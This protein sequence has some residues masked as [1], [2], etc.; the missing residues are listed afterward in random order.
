MNLILACQ[1]WRGLRD[2]GAKCFRHEASSWLSKGGHCTHSGIRFW[3]D[4]APPQLLPGLWRT[5]NSSGALDKSEEC[6]VLPSQLVA[7]QFLPCALC[8][9]LTQAG[10]SYLIQAPCASASSKGKS[11]ESPKE[12]WPNTPITMIILFFCFLFNSLLQQLVRLRSLK[13]CQAFGGLETQ[14]V[15]CLDRSEECG[16][17]G[18]AK[19]IRSLLGHA[20]LGDSYRALYPA[21]TQAGTSYLIQAP[22]ASTSSKG[23]SV[24]S[25]KEA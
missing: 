16:V 17:R 25:P 20:K 11:V 23:K 24:E 13:L 18:A 10:A 4:L 9:A 22:C 6:R 19:P 7:G 14:V 21:L 8:C 12:A 3:A 2:S 5:G 1:G 15:S